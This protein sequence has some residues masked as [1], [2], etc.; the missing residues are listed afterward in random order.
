MATRLCLTNR[1][2]PLCSY[3]E[4]PSSQTTAQ[5]YEMSNVLTSLPIYL[6]VISKQKREQIRAERADS[7][8]DPAAVEDAVRRQDEYERSFAALWHKIV[9]RLGFLPTGETIVNKAL[10]WM[11]DSGRAIDARWPPKSC[12]IGN[13]SNQRGYNLRALILCTIL[14]LLVFGSLDQ[15]V[16]YLLFV[17]RASACS[18]TTVFL[19]VTVTITGNGSGAAPDTT[20]TTDISSTSTSTQ[21]VTS[22]VTLGASS[23]TPPYVYTVDPSGSTVWVNGVTPTGAS[24]VT[25]TTSVFVTPSDPAGG[26]TTT[27]PVASVTPLAYTST[28]YSFAGPETILTSTSTST[29]TV[30][31]TLSYA[32]PGSTD[33]RSAFPGISSAGWNA[34]SSSDVSALPTLTSSVAPDPTTYTSIYYTSS[35]LL[36][37]S[38]TTTFMTTTI[39]RRITVTLPASSSEASPEATKSSSLGTG[40]WPSTL[41]SISTAQSGTLVGPKSASMSS[42]LRSMTTLPIPNSLSTLLTTSASSYSASAS[43][44]SVSSSGSSSTQTGPS[45]STVGSS[46]LPS[47]ASSPGSSSSGVEITNTMS[48]APTTELSS[49]SLA[50]TWTSPYFNSSSG[51]SSSSTTMQTTLSPS[52]S[53]SLAVSSTIE[54][55]PASGV[56]ITR[57][58]ASS[59]SSNT[60]PSISSTLSGSKSADASSA[61]RPTQGSSSSSPSGYASSSNTVAQ[62]SETSASTEVS[63]ESTSLH[64]HHT[65]TET[66]ISTGQPATKSSS[67]E[68]VS[69][70]LS[71]SLA[72]SS[73]SSTESSA[74]SSGSAIS[75][76]SS[77][78]MT[79]TQTSSARKTAST[80]TFSNP[81]PASSPTATPTGGC[82]EHGS[83]LVD[84]DNLPNFLPTNSNNTNITQAPPIESPYWHLTWSDGYVYAPQPNEP[85]TSI[86]PP[87]LAVFLAD[88]TGKRVGGA[89]SGNFSK[90]GEIS[91]GPREA[92]SAFWF[93]AYSAWFGCDNRGPEDCTL[94]FSAFS[95]SPKDKTEVLIDKSTSKIEPCNKSRSCGLSLV[96][97][98]STFK[99][100]S[101]LQIQAY[102]GEEE[103]MFFMDDLSLNWSNNTCAAGLLRQSST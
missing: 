43:G 85:Y 35:G 71:S 77:T 92:I 8:V 2:T 65:T 5:A 90:P 34:T 42:S 45:S 82:G 26:D 19:P 67:P 7:V 72:S 6:Q 68:A 84:F 15:L 102:V 52:T 41:S 50:N 60:K 39:S 73:N 54:S 95:W 20:S 66:V 96:E 80:S 9:A 22:Y 4:K 17:T 1:D 99:S 33:T 46:S 58:M 13:S 100:L 25:L 10:S 38:T 28:T 44:S 74:I 57:T 24:F 75:S 70:T 18:T 47:P 49:L 89:Q 30:T 56:S 48:H 94:T 69:K 55:S 62:S 32:T 79:H 88:G 86:S 36:T 103:R 93:D 97:F 63:T 21:T 98:P 61:A 11:D 51:V 31:Y 16:K 87:H 27:L 78:S 81:F 76:S 40:G 53:G 83:F 37:T 101:G 23:E 29:N 14:I 64:H 59:S 91:D 12:M 3:V